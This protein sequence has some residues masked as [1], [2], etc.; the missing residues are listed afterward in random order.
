MDTSQKLTGVVLSDIRKLSPQ[1]KSGLT[2][3]KEFHVEVDFSDATIEDVVQGAFSQEVIRLANAN[4]PKWDQLPDPIV[5]KVKYK[6]PVG[7]K[8][9]NV[10]EELK[11]LG[12]KNEVIDLVMNNPEALNKLLNK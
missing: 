4:R 3:E 1:E 11:K 5:L 2:G 10:R 9:V 6:A 8:G 12:L 7:K